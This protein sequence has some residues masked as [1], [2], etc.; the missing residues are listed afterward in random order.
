VETKISEL[1]DNLESDEVSASSIID[2]IATLKEL[3]YLD[4]D[5]G[6]KLVVALKIQAM[7][8]PYALD[9][10]E[11]LIWLAKCQEGRTVFFPIFHGF[12]F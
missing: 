11:T 9:D 2:S 7:S 5:A 8:D 10:F 12:F 3:A 1:A 4:S 6:K